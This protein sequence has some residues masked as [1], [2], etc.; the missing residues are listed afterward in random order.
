MHDLNVQFSRFYQLRLVGWLCFLNHSIIM[1]YQ[2][3]TIVFHECD[4]ESI[5]IPV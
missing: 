5:C 4:V 1:K 3:I 2:T